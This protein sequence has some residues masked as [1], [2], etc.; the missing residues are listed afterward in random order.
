MT[1]EADTNLAL[2][3]WNAVIGAAILIAAELLLVMATTASLELFGLPLLQT[4]PQRDLF[5]LA[6]VLGICFIGFSFA[7]SSGPLEFIGR[8]LAIGFFALPTILLALSIPTTPGTYAAILVIQV[9]IAVWFLDQNLGAMAKAK[10]AV[11]LFYGGVW[12]ALSIDAIGRYTSIDFAKTIP[13]HPAL[14]VFNDF[15]LLI[16]GGILTCWLVGAFLA[17]IWDTKSWTAPLANPFAEERNTGRWF[18]IRDGLEWLAHQVFVAVDIGWRGLA[19][20]LVLLKCY[21]GHLF[22]DYIKPVFDEGYLAPVLRF[23]LSV[24]V[25][26]GVTIG[27]RRV[28]SLLVDYLRRPSGIAES[29]L[30]RL[31]A[32]ALEGDV[33]RELLSLGQTA[34]FML[35]VACCI[36]FEAWNWSVGGKTPEVTRRIV[37][38]LGIVIVSFAVTGILATVLSWSEIGVV[39]PGFRYCGVVS[40]AA[41]SAVVLF[42]LGVMISRRRAD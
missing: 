23:M 20:A 29:V 11:L 40:A 1:T 25:I 26:G 8:I 22:R 19:N 24:G 39:G 15:R 14:G 13:L 38:V 18:G 5:I 42:V 35:I 3:G 12:I 30:G 17:M 37:I 9:S 28:A 10:R 34:F 4:A 36:V 2:R 21:A 27:A 6:F 32:N 7:V 33:A 41:M 31:E 16:A